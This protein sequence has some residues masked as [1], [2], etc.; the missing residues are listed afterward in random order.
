MMPFVLFVALMLSLLGKVAGRIFW[1]SLAKGFPVMSTW[2]LS[3][4]GS[5]P[6]SRG[7]YGVEGVF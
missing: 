2:M 6:E 3:C 1:F 5:I 4:S 7:A